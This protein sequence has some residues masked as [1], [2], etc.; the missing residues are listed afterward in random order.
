MKTLRKIIEILTALETAFIRWQAS[1]SATRA[2]VRMALNG[3]RV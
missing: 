1:R 3:C 2:A